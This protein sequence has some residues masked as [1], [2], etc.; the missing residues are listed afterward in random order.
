[1]LVFQ[2]IV[3]HLLNGVKKFLANAL[4]INFQNSQNLDPV[5]QEIR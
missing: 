1:M 3:T 2:L 4:K 5:K